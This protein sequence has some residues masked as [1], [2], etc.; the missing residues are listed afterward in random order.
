M[1][2]DGPADR[3]GLP[4]ASLTEP[5]RARVA[6]A[7]KHGPDRLAPRRVRA[8]PARDARRRRPPRRSARRPGGSGAYRSRDGDRVPRVVVEVRR[9]RRA[10]PSPPSLCGGRERPGRT[11]RRSRQ[12]V[13]AA[14]TRRPRRR[15]RATRRAARPAR[16]RPATPRAPRRPHD[17]HRA[18]RLAPPPCRRGPSSRAAALNDAPAY[19]TPTPSSQRILHASRPASGRVRRRALKRRREPRLCDRVVVQQQHPVGPALDG[20][21]DA[22]VVAAGEAEIRAECESA[23]RRGK[24]SST[25]LVR[26]VGRAVVD[27]DRLDALERSKRS[28]RVLATVPVEDD[29]DRAASCAADEV[30]DRASAGLPLPSRIALDLG[31]GAR[32][33]RIDVAVVRRCRPRRGRA[34]ARRAARARSSARSRP[35]RPRTN[36]RRR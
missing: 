36:G 5:P 11:R 7:C 30:R 3:S 14:T 6:P 27:A 12:P 8:A 29:G 9:R 34:D 4:R 20:T 31:N 33:S 2:R 10:L 23:R 17:R 25:T 1:G 21:A 35:S 18:A 32:D 13:C 16:R 19:C 26:P 15:G 28:K 22:G 24:R